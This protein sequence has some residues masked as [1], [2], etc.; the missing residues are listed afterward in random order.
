MEY[1]LLPD[2]MLLSG[3]LVLFVMDIQLYCT[4]IQRANCKYKL[5]TATFT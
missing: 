3:Y 1:S 4:I 2:A 5:E